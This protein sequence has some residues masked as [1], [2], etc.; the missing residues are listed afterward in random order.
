[1]QQK[2][3]AML[4][5]AARIR[6]VDPDDVAERVLTT[7]FIPD[8]MGNLRAFS[9]QTVRC[10]RCNT[11]YRR[12]PL[13]GKCPRCGGSIL[14]TIHEASV[15][16]YLEVSRKICSAFAISEYTRQRIAVLEMAIQSTFGEAPEKQ[17]GLADFM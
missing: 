7:H 5:L 10:T 8:L 13:A 3:E 11:K 12:V 16:K 2:L 17:M 4:T 9:N 1:M 14:P 15:K 6:A